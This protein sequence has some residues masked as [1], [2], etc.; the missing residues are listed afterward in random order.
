MSWLNLESGGAYHSKAT[1]EDM[2]CPVCGKAKGLPIHGDCAKQRKPSHSHP[3]RCIHAKDMPVDPKAVYLTI[4]EVASMA[5]CSTTS[6]REAVNN[7]TLPAL[8][9]RGFRLN[10]RKGGYKLYVVHPDAARAWVDAWIAEH[11]QGEAGR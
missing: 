2:I 11:G 4:R 6:V 1:A 8:G 3:G 5:R 7:G 9:A 10:S